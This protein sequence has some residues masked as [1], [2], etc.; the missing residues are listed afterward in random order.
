MKI[1]QAKICGMQ[2]KHWL[3]GNLQHYML[4]ED[5]SVNTNYLHFY[6]K[7]IMQ[8]EQNKLKVSIRKN[9]IKV[10]SQVA[11]RKIVE[12]INKDKT[13]FLESRN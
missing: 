5:E 13:C 7:K 9:T 4:R 10:I 12:R 11:N 3:E 6:L 1:Q 8:E 2:L